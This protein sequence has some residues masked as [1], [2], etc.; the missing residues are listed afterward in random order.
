MNAERLG[1]YM[2]NLNK[3]NFTEI[4]QWSLRDITKIFQRTLNHSELHNIYKNI[5]IIH[6]ILFYTLSSINKEEINNI[7][8]QV[9][10]IIIDIFQYSEEDKNKLYKC[11]DSK[12]EFK[13]DNME[14]WYIFKGECCISLDIFKDNFG[15]SENSRIEDNPLYKLNTLLE[16]LFQIILSTDKEPILL[17]G[18]SGYKTFLAQKLVSNSQTITLNQESSIEQLLGT[19]S[20]FLKSEINDFYLRLIILI[21]GFNNYVELS[22][23]LREKKLDKKELDMLINSKKNNLPKSFYYA[24]D[25]CCDK[26]FQKK[27]REDEFNPL[28]NMEIA[29]KPGLFL[30]AILGGYNLI[31]KNISN[32]PTIILERFNELFSGKCIITINEDITNTISD[33]KN[34]KIISDFYKKFRVFGT[35]PPGANSLL[36]EAI[37]SKFTLIYVGEYA[38]NEYET[39]L[40]SYC[41]LKGLYTITDNNIININKYSQK[42]NS[43]FSGIN[44]TL[45]QMTNIL[46]LAHNINK[47]IKDIE[48]NNLTS[49]DV[50]FIIFYY[51]VRGILDNRENNVLINLLKEL[52]NNDNLKKSLE[53]GLKK[54]TLQF[55]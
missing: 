1:K 12:A 30:N 29:F 16:D 51:S 18:P 37:I 35:C 53:E 28:S 50:L 47:N 15:F 23:K 24:L 14:N 46:N 19:T 22:Q 52:Y 36:S 38:L 41:D 9:I 5:K 31:L 6:E 11:F 43:V 2:I 34:N 27:K 32:L 44:I 48:N 3:K 20:F 13:K 8:K 33:E 49:D 40:R 54:K 17:I 25:T 7:S 10:D 55:I 21:C 4:S 39:V 42:L 45:F 26:L